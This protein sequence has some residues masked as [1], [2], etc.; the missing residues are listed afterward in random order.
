MSISDALF[1]LMTHYKTLSHAKI[2]N[3]NAEIFSL[4]LLLL[5]LLFLF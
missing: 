1:T 3:T 5:S 4:I 2:V